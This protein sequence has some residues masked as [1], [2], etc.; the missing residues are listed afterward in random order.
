M[1]KSWFEMNS[2]QQRNYS[3]A[4]WIP[5]YACQELEHIGEIGWDGYKSEIFGCGTLAVPMEIKNRAGEMGW[6]SIGIRYDSIPWIDDKGNYIASD[7]CMDLEN[8]FLGIR[9]A[10]KQNTESSEPS[11]L[12]LHQD[13]ILALGLKREG[14]TWVRPEEGYIEV[15]HIK[16]NTEGTPIFLEVRA[17]HLKDYLCARKM[18]LRITSYR[19]RV[20]ITTNK[21]EFVLDAQNTN[22][23]ADRKWV[24][25]IATIHEGGQPFGAKMAIFHVSRNDVDFSEDVP[26]MGEETD[27]N[28]DLTFQEKEFKGKQCYRLSGEL[29]KNEWIEPS[30][31]SPRVANDKTPPTIY[32]ITDA[33]GHRENKDTLIEDGRWLWFNPSIVPDILSRRGGNLEWYTVETGKVGFLMSWNVHFGINKLG[34]INVYASDIA[35]LPDWIQ[36]IWAGH[37]VPPDGKVSKELLEAQVH[38]HPSN[39]QAPEDYLSRG[40]KLLNHISSRKLGFNIIRENDALYTILKKCHRFRCN[41]KDETI[42]SF[43]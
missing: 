31:Y 2:I 22:E 7:I 12:Y 24:G 34:L 35:R 14:D 15:A 9:L 11:E 33:E 43:V 42:S 19:E 17:E 39:T 6:D 10:L 16:R 20:E 26:I 4:V 27:I 18:A 5:L 1:E 8:K 41:S 30:E 13:F 21:P 37:N 23:N 29:W 40:I 32:F 38:A 25:N 3:S 28:T 36:Q